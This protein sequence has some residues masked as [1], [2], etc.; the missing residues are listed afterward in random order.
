MPAFYIIIVILL[1]I[2][3]FALSRFYKS[4]GKS[5][6]NAI[7]STI[8]TITE[9][10]NDDI[11][12]ADELR[13]LRVEASEYNINDAIFKYCSE[14]SKEMKDTMKQHDFKSFSAPVPCELEDYTD[15]IC[16]I[17]MEHGYS[18]VAIPSKDP[19]DGKKYYNLKISF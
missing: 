3:F 9:E 10:D 18:A 15:D 8:N 1:I 6:G 4:I 12:T 17:M 13:K 7:K 2:A 19:A 14:L 5:A 16:E 11:I